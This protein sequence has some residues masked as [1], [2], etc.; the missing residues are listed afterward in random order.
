M[1]VMRPRL[2]LGIHMRVGVPISSAPSMPVWLPW[3]TTMM[4]APRRSLARRR[5]FCAPRMIRVVVSAKPAT[6]SAHSSTAQLR[7]ELP[8]IFLS[9]SWTEV[10]LGLFAADLGAQDDQAGERD[11]GA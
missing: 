1:A 3:G 7:K 9:A 11:Q 8:W 10:I 5:L 4:S 6:T 2:A